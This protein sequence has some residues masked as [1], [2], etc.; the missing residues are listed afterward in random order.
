M[1]KNDFH[2]RKS[3]MNF[4]INQKITDFFHE[5]NNNNKIVMKSKTHIDLIDLTVE[6]TNLLFNIKHQ[7]LQLPSS[8]ISTNP[9]KKQQQ[10]NKMNETIDKLYKHIMFRF[11]VQTQRSRRSMSRES[12]YIKWMVRWT[13]MQV[14]QVA[15]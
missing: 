15:K 14:E 11:R 4:F 3:L 13:R 1:K 10:T 2:H 8:S 5:D 6:L 12:E 9:L 7:Y